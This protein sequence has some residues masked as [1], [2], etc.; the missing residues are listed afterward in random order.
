L[1]LP[2]DPDAF[3]FLLLFENDLAVRAPL[4][5]RVATPV[6]AHFFGNSHEHWVVYRSVEVL[7]D[8][9]FSGLLLEEKEAGQD[10]DI[11][12]NNKG[13]NWQIDTRQDPT[14]IENSAANGLVAWVAKDSIWQHNTHPPPLTEPLD[15]AG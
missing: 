1:I 4:I 14:I 15:R 5:E 3:F 6:K 13:L 11:C 2:V 8:P 12:L 10:I 9:F 7:G